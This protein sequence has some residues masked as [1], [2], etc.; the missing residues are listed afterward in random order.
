MTTSKSL[1]ANNDQ[2]SSDWFLS[3]AELS[4][5]RALVTFDIRNVITDIE[6]FEHIEKPFVTGTLVMV[7]VERVVERFDI[8]GAESLLLEIQRTT[9]NQIKPIEKRFVID[10]IK[11]VKRPNETSAV[12]H[13]HFTEDI[14]YKSALVNVNKAYAGEPQKIIRTIA[15]DYLEKE[16][17]T[18]ANDDVA[19][20]MQVIVPNMTPV[21]AMSWIKNRSTTSE[22]YP[23][24]LFSNFATSNLFFLD[25]GTMLSQVP[26]NES[27]PYMYAQSSGVVD[28]A[29]RHMQIYDYHLQNHETTLQL[30]QKGFI[31]AQHSFYDVTLGKYIKKKFSVHDDVYDKTENLNKRQNRPV[32]SYDLIMDDEQLSEYESR[33][34]FNTYA[35][36]NFDDNHKSY[37]EERDEGGHARKVSSLAM[38]NLLTKNPIEIVVDGREFITGGQSKT[39][40]NIIKVVFKS[41]D[42]GHQGQKIDR[43]LSGDYLVMAARHVFAKEQCRTKLLISKIANYNSDIYTQ[44]ADR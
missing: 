23:F 4:A 1:N 29:H 35:S 13:L 24:Y 9:N 22:G 33:A 32:V 6:I 7:D 16:V 28:T 10:S 31:G 36:K 30:V 18:T 12:V 8:Q 39:I 27:Y 42:H 15:E 5:P 37:T 14:G 26:L 17:K 38:K 3:K 44:G 41:T 34:I 25:L 11:S 20:N 21:E 2:S 40:G 43:K 19:N